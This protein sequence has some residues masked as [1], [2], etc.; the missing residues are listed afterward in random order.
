MAFTDSVES[1]PDTSPRAEE[2]E[3]RDFS[4]SNFKKLAKNAYPKTSIAIEM[5]ILTEKKGY[6]NSKLTQ[7]HVLN[8]LVIGRELVEFNPLTTGSTLTSFK[9]FNTHRC[10]SY[11]TPIHLLNFVLL[12]CQNLHLSE[13]S[14]L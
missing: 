9:M 11:Q 6:K 13:S 14:S 1:C 8:Q 2:R 10:S 12:K 3:M 4:V 5:S 7:I